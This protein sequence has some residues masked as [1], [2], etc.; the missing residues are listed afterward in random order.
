MIP[1][2][3][4]RVW[5]GPPMPD[6]LVAYGR[7]WEDHHSAWHHKLWTEDNLPPLR[8]QALYD[9]AHRIA[10]DH[11]GQ[12]RAD[13]VRYELLEQFGGVYVD[14]DFECRKPLDPLLEGVECFAAW[15]VPNRWINNAILGAVPGHPLM[16]ML[17]RR[18]PVNVRRRRGA[19]PNKLSGPQFLTPIARQFDVTVF[20][21]ELFYPFLWDE[22]GTD[23][24]HSDHPDAYAVHHWNHKRTLI[25]GA[26]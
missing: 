5:V 7:T 18:L 9:D 13:V 20:D 1:P 22:I 14:A 12:F 3:I 4:H 17:I 23:R 25:A 11:V 24:D 21:K 2:L 8:N 10:P 15:E 16:D 6:R 26:S 19:R